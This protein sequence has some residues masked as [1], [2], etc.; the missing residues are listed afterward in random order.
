MNILIIAGPPYS[1][2][3]TQC[4]ILEKQLKYKHISTGSRLRWEKENNTD[5]GQ[6]SSSYEEKGNLIPDD[7]MKELYKQILEENKSQDGIILDGYPRTSAQVDDFVEILEEKNLNVKSVLNIDVP[8]IELL[9]RAKHRASTSTRKDDK[10]PEIHIK[11]IEV[12]ESTTKPA[13]DYLKTKMAVTDF[14]GTGSI[15]EITERILESVNAVAH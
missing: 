3:G 2:K 8:T 9:K 4:E 5:F 13:I 1:G 10:D 15:K 6:V 12:Y 14:D 11:R 7:L